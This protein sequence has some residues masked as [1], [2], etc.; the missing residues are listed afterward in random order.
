MPMPAR[1]RSS[2][3][4]GCGSG[5]RDVGQPVGPEGRQVGGG[6]QGAEGLVRADVAGRLV[7]ADVLLAGAQRHDEGAAPVEVG[8][9]ADE[10]TRDLAQERLAAGQQAEVGAAV[11]RRDAERLALPG[12][13]VGA[14]LPGRREDGQR[15]GLDDGHEERPGRVRQLG[16]TAHGLEDAEGVGLAEDDAGHGPVGVGQ[17]GLEGGQVGRAVG[18]RGQL[19]ELP[20]SRRRSTSASSRRSDDGRRG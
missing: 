3:R 20:R 2:R 1:A 17:G 19:L 4:A 11:L 12:R 15:D 13:D 16:R 8:G 10:A 6:R 9:P 5:R 18:Q 7:A 14:V